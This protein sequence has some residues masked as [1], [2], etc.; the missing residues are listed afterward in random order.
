MSQ[1][2]RKSASHAISNSI[3][4]DYIAYLDR[5]LSDM[6]AA[7]RTGNTREMSRLRK[8]LSGKSKSSMTTPSKD[9]QGNPIL[10][11]DHLLSAWN[12]F[13]SQKFASPDADNDRPREHTV[14]PHDTLSDQELE[15]ALASLK[16]GK[17]PGIDL[18]PIE[19]Y[20]QSPSAKAELFRLTR[21]IWDTEEC[22]DASVLGIFLM[23]YKKNDRNDFGN[24][25]A[26]C[27]LPHGYKL[28]SAIIA[29]RL[30]VQLAD[31]LPDSQA[32][33]RP[34]RGTRDN[35]CALKWSISMILREGRKAI[36]TF[37]DYKAAFD[38]ESQLFLDE[39]LSAA[40][41]SIKVRRVIQSVFK[42]ASGCVRIGNETSN[43]FNIS[44]GVLQGDIFSP[45]AFIA[46]LWRIFATH[47]SPNAGIVLGTAPHTVKVSSLEYADDAGLLDA[48][49]TEAS[50]RM[51][52]I[53]L[54]SRE[55]AAMIISV[56]KT[57]AMHIHKSIQVTETKEEEIEAL[58]LK[59]KC[60]DCQRAFPTLH[61]LRVHMGRWCD[62]GQTIRS[63]KGSLAD[64]AVQLT[65]RKAA[66]NL[67]PHVYIEGE[68]IENV[69]AFVY[70]GSKLQCDGEDLAD[71]KHRLD[72]A[73][74][75]FSS[76]SRFWQDSRLP[77]TFKLRIYR[78][79]VS[80]TLTHACEAWTLT[81]NVQQKINGFN[82]RCL[83]II[84]GDSYR[85]TATKPVFNLVRAIR[86]RRFK[87]LG[88]VLRMHPDRLVRQTFLAYVNGPNGAPDGS[89][90]DDCQ[91]KSINSLTSLAHDRKGWQR[92]MNKCVV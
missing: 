30:H 82:S 84:T 75:E 43:P 45:V 22:P 32:G 62:G 90:L 54:G 64:K 36:I 63:R 26:L 73:Q 19:A 33:F 74:A 66:E 85:N 23:M 13:L 37:I 71:V 67:R 65:K 1:E 11:Q 88:H 47:D 79:A 80:T 89:L 61:G 39:A 53:S 4:D 51:T 38:T 92:F 57:K 29:R 16:S 14:S 40:N 15:E 2:D 17:A 10:S 83:H 27:L 72:I 44:R 56:P 7:D 28:L 5:I 18:I 35:V 9:M 59:H 12:E 8:L 20:Q 58:H 81:S 68:E 48:T 78:S 34:A 60:P 55:D 86:R 50:T 31:I 87:Y 42:V 6:E 69:H 25:R 70:L 24:Y 49:V 52:A 76:L 77:I 91:G 21:L 41:V 46:G 3:R